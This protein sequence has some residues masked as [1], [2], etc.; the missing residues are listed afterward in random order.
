LFAPTKETR[1]KERALFAEETRCAGW[2]EPLQMQEACK[3]GNKITG[4]EVRVYLKLCLWIPSSPRIE[5]EREGAIG[6]LS[7]TKNETKTEGK[8]TRK[9]KGLE[10]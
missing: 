7:P 1:K 5:R 4:R 6:G 2:D 10:V 8:K 9:R 3:G